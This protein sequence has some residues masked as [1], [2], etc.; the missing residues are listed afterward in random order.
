MRRVTGLCK[1]EVESVFGVEKRD[2]ER[3]RSI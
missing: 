1:R 3:G 2:R